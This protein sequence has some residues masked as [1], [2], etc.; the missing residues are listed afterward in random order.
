MSPRYLSVRF[1]NFELELSKPL[2]TAKGEIDTRRGTLVAVEGPKGQMGIGE[3]TPLPGWT[4]PVKESRRAL[5]EVATQSPQEALRELSE[6]PAARH[7]VSLSLLDASARAAEQSL[8]AYLAGDEKTAED[9]PVNATIGLGSPDAAAREAKQAAESGFETVKLKV[10]GGAL[11]EDVA[12]VRA[13]DEAVDDDI[14]VR[15]DAN[16]AWKPSTA[17]KAVEAFASLDVE[18]VEQPVPGEQL[19][20]LADLR[21]R[22]VD[23][24]AD[25]ALAHHE[26]EE[27]LGGSAADVLVLKPMALGGIDNARKTA[28]SAAAEG[29]E[30]VVTTTIDAVIA[31]TAAVHLAASIPNV[32]ACGFATASMLAED[33]GTDPAPVEDGVV[34]VPMERGVAD[35]MF[36]SLF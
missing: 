16:G 2:S 8:A 20:A 11:T 5:R 10:G 1:R 3:T 7:G 27:I 13:I 35:G 32:R 29:I 4:E 25:E 34:R 6:Q 19:R 21:N 12:R 17:E 31:R 15:V 22:G 9:V 26:A 28:I 14:S 33:L 18:Y 23:I 24:A 36:D 30:T